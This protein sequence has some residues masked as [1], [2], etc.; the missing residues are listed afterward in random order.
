MIWTLPNGNRQHGFLGSKELIREDGR[1]IEGL[2]EHGCGHPIA[3]IG[4]WLEWYGTHG[5]CG[6]CY[7]AKFWLDRTWR[8]GEIIGKDPKVQEATNPKTSEGS[9][10]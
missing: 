6:C 7:K 3:S 4:P 1:R 8:P 9:K 2:C 10:G 5:C